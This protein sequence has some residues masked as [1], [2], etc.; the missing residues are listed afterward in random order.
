MQ[1]LKMA[2]MQSE[3]ERQQNR[4]SYIHHTL[5]LQRKIFSA[6]RDT[7]EEMMDQKMNREYIA[8]EM[9]LKD[10]LQHKGSELIKTRQLLFN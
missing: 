1:L 3:I 10:G 6:W 8:V 7:V 9:T 2:V 4:Q 5:G